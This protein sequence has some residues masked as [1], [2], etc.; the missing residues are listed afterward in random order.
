[1]SLS[2]LV[3]CLRCAAGVTAGRSPNG[4]A[5][6]RRTERGGNVVSRRASFGK[7]YRSRFFR[8]SKNT[9]RLERG[10]VFRL[11]GGR[12]TEKHAGQARVE[13]LVPQLHVL[14]ASAP[15]LCALRPGGLLRVP[16]ELGLRLERQA[17]QLAKREGEVEDVGRRRRGRVR[18]GERGTRKQTR[19]QVRLGRERQISFSTGRS[20][21]HGSREA[22][23][24]RCSGVSRVPRLFLSFGQ[25]LVR[26]ARKP[27]AT[28]EP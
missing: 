4:D 16:A 27:N 9:G 25:N 15:V 28:D 21:V 7:K 12:R 11:R 1:M 24:R 2:S 22:R 8:F 3:F 23:L 5:S 17:P 14:D 20:V 18:G 13:V 10:R 6:G 26:S 19:R